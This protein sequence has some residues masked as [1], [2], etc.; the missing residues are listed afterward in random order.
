MLADH[1]IPVRFDGA[2]VWHVDPQSV[3]AIDRRIEPDLSNAAPFLAA[4]LVTGGAVTVPDWPE[5]TTQAGDALRGLLAT[6]GAEVA[7]GPLGLTVSGGGVIRGIDVDLADAGE[8]A[9]TIA[10]IAVFADGPTTLR[11]ISHLRGHETDR[12]AALTAELNGLG[13]SVTETSDGLVIRP[14]PLSGGVFHTYRD[15]RMATTAAVIGLRVPGVEI[16]DVATTNKT[17]PQFPERWTSMLNPAGS[18]V[19]SA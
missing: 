6:M 9:P 15:H 16:E 13:G 5:Q 18:P 1:G 11:G 3:R 2:N 12:L 8:L 14:R 19:A 17:L 7:L 10:A 4:A